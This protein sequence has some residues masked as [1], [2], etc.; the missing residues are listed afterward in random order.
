MARDEN[1]II[2]A[3]V[4]IV[5]T[6]GRSALVLRR[7][8]TDRAFPGHWCFPGGQAHPRETTHKAAEREV[9]EET[10]LTVH[11]LERLGQREST[12]ATGR[13]YLV[14][15]FLT[16]VWSGSLIT[17]PTAEHAAALWA[18]FESL[19]DLEP[20]GPTTRWLAMEIHSR[21]TIPEG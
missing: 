9:L 4:G 21:F 2:S 5:D 7:F 8:G 10:G 1:K 19:P 15:C 11:R 3:I 14:D 18:P 12:G 16:D 6:A 17:F 20:T 13:S